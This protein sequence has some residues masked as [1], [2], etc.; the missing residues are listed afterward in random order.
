ME[1]G[2]ASTGVAGLDQLLGGGIP[3]G[4]VLCVM[5]SFG[6]GKTTLGLQ[7]LGEG[8]ARG[9]RAVFVSLEEEGPDLMVAA[10]N[11][12]IDLAK[13][14][15]DG[16]FTI[17]KLSL[18]DARAT[19]RRIN[20]DL[21]GMIREARA[22]RVVLDSVSLLNSVF[23]SDAERRA[24]L[25]EVC[26]A[27]RSSR[28]TGVITAELADPNDRFAS[29]D[30]LVEYVADGVVAL[31]HREDAGGTG[32]L[33]LEVAVLKMRR[34]RRSRRVVPFE[35]TDAGLA[36]DGNGDGGAPKAAPRRGRAGRG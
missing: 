27:I 25:F 16:R 22:D 20:S 15:D 11:L 2:R 18:I 31:Q 12:G 32:A 3:R 19:L 24:V 14:V 36:V 8:L 9:E 17:L 13:S 26:D 23:A 1:D 4:F 7:F 28:A 29:R 5:G 35:I 21:L 33:H 10:R 30:G 6:T 34:S